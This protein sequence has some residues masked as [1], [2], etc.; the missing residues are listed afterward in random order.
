MSNFQKTFSSNISYGNPIGLTPNFTKDK[1]QKSKKKKNGTKNILKE[2]ESM[3]KTKTPGLSKR[4][5][6]QLFSTIKLQQEDVKEMVSK[7]PEKARINANNPEE[8]NLVKCEVNQ[9]KDNNQISDAKL[10]MINQVTKG[11]GGNNIRVFIRFRPL[12]EVEQELIENG[13]GCICVE[14]LDEKEDGRCN[15]IQI[16]NPNG[17]V[18]HPY[19]VDRVFQSE[20]SQD[21]IYDYF[22]KDIV[23]DVLSGYNGTIFAYGQSG[24]G[25]TFTMYG[26]DIYDDTVKGIIPRLIQDI[27]NYVDKA[28]DNVIF[29][30][31]MS[32]LQIYKEVIYDLLTGEKDLKIKESPHRGIYV[33]KLTEVYINTFDNFMEYVELA[34][35]N[36]IV[37]ETKLNQNS[38]RSHSILIFEVTQNVVNDNF[39]KTGKLN[40]VDL[41]GSEKISKTGAVGET[42]EEAKKINLS[43]SSL[44]NVIHALTSNADH[45]P[46]RDSKLTRILQE[47]LGGNY[48]TSLIVTCSP[49]SYHLEETTSSLQFA[50]RVKR[51]KNK[52]KINIQL[53]YEELQKI[54]RQLRHKLDLSQKEIS[55]LKSLV[56]E[57]VLIENGFNNETSEKDKSNIHKRNILSPTDDVK[58]L[59]NSDDLSSVSLQGD[60]SNTNFMFSQHN[61]EDS[62]DSA[63]F[64]LNTDKKQNT[65]QY[66]SSRFKDTTTQEEEKNKESDVKLPKSKSF[67]QMKE[68]VEEKAKE[69]QKNENNQNNLHKETKEKKVTKEI[70]ECK[71]ENKEIVVK[72]NEDI[73]YQLIRK[74]KNKIE[75]LNNEIKEKDFIIS[76]LEQ[77]KKEMREN[78][79][80]S[81]KKDEKGKSSNVLFNNKNQ[82]DSPPLFKNLQDFYEEI[83]TKIGAI[84]QKYEDIEKFELNMSEYNK[85]TEEL[86]K[87][88]RKKCETNLKNNFDNSSNGHILFFDNISN[89]LS[90]TLQI[91][92]DDANCVFDFNTTQDLFR[93]NVSRIFDDIFRIISPQAKNVE[94]KNKLIKYISLFLF[95]YIDSY[96]TIQLTS[97][98]NY[99]LNSENINLKNTNNTL[100][101]LV[102][103]LLK[104]N[105]ELANMV[106][107]YQNMKLRASI[108]ESGFNMTFAGENDGTNQE[109]KKSFAE[110]TVPTRISKKRILTFV[111]RKNMDV[112]KAL[113]E[114]NSNLNLNAI[115]EGIM[116]PAS[117]R[118][119]QKETMNTNKNLLSFTNA[120]ASFASKPKNSS[121]NLENIIEEQPQGQEQNQEEKNNRNF[122]AP[123]RHV[124]MFLPK[125]EKKMSKLRMIKQFVIKSLQQEDQYK[126]EQEFINLNLKKLIK[127]CE[128]DLL[129]KLVEQQIVPKKELDY[130]DGENIENAKKEED[131]DDGNEDNNNKIFN[132]SHNEIMPSEHNN[133]NKIIKE[134]GVSQF[135]VNEPNNNHHFGSRQLKNNTILKRD[136]NLYTE[137]DKQNYLHSNISQTDYKNLNSFNYSSNNNNEP[138]SS[139]AQNLK[140][141]PSYIDSNPYYTN[142]PVKNNRNIFKNVSLDFLNKKIKFPQRNLSILK[143]PDIETLISDYLETGTATRKFDGISVKVENNKIRCSYSGGLNAQNT[144]QSIPIHHQLETNNGDDSLISENFSDG[145]E[146]NLQKK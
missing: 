133:D 98:L 129:R 46:Y 38:S 31:K 142:F 3:K 9:P 78:I 70:V 96:I 95:G 54:I 141:V 132:F 56:P 120:T 41:A 5:S 14:Y 59:I 48:K 128:R 58:K 63:T 34:Q 105:L 43:L 136:A 40:L 60:L 26:S 65:Y 24:S 84:Q 37:G 91:Y 123:K 6:V 108:V 66:S 49:H 2:I 112:L 62:N 140:S 30:F 80:S 55:R 7:S 122:F 39:S 19:M 87:N 73:N 33:D 139:S 21:I 57:E 69:E 137:T 10:E 124:T 79:N 77:S 47:S 22:G 118:N 97:Q 1:E 127:K 4:R 52:V 125:M 11:A 107:N 53:T 126:K 113:R 90:K 85:N 115:A 27:F 51:I 86:I 15:T 121:T 17:N 100:F 74:L 110:G 117:P 93:E 82:T 68:E 50:T 16:K 36:R 45:I 104:S 92:K 42:L 83:K 76:S 35:E 130:Y 32:F 13:V 29:Q 61:K 89:L 28:D 75:T 106:N 145:D 64:D 8:F 99:K 25:K 135:E 101:S 119:V 143:S 102:D 67:D 88:L 12:N 103:S 134:E 114:K 18:S 138:F 44:G 144:I 71:E 72:T 81:A 111:S 23:K 109:N 131:G 146:D 94:E 20:T 116:G